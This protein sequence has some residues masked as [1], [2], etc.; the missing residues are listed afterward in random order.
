MNGDD[1]IKDEDEDW[2]N[3]DNDSS[4]SDEDDSEQEEEEEQNGGIF[5]DDSSDGTS[6]GKLSGG[7]KEGSGGN[8]SN[9]V[10]SDH[11]EVRRKHKINV[12]ELHKQLF[13]TSQSK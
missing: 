12:K 11:D 10:G 7:I 6:D 9:G 1:E 8:G 13:F 3:S 2:D 4:D 5:T